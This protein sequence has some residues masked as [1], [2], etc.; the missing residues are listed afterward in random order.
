MHR[1]S[2]RRCN[3][4][5]WSRLVSFWLQYVS[6]QQDLVFALQGAGWAGA[7]RSGSFMQ[8]GSAMT[9]GG[10][11]GGSFGL[12][13]MAPGPWDGGLQPAPS[14]GK[15]IS[16]GADKNAGNADICPVQV[17]YSRAGSTG[18]LPPKPSVLRPG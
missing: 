14:Q 6:C 9:P 4:T 13:G 10:R 7:G 12:P 8:P 17:G 3:N 15:P 1:G 16:L 5:A 18:L 11:A 2:R